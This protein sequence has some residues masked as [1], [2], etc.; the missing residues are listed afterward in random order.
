MDVADHIAQLEEHGIGLAAA[1]QQA[2]LDAAVP[3]C[4]QWTVRDLMAHCGGVHR[5]AT[6]I[7]RDRLDHDPVAEPRDL[8]APGEADVFAWYRDSHATLVRTL[9]ESDPDLVCFA[10]LPAP[11]PLAFW[12]RRQAHE[13]SIHRADAE[14]ASGPISPRDDAFALDGIDEL[15]TGFA[16]RR[17]SFRGVDRPRQLGLRPHGADAWL[18]TLTPDGIRPTR[19][20]GDPE[21][22]ISGSASD[23]Y[24]WLWNRPASVQVSGDQAVADLWRAMRVRWS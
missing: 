6:S 9:R 14:S 22:L 4:P 5:W 15:L 24:L 11:S 20:V 19:Q 2:G 12:A 1:A 13:T 3:P 10:F 21:C 8:E 18:A 7:V 17:R 23:L 16:A